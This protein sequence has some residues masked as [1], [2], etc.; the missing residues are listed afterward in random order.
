MED[1][2]ILVPLVGVEVVEEDHQEVPIQVQDQEI[3]PQLVHH[4]EMQEHQHHL[5][6]MVVE[7]EV[8]EL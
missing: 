1:N 2:L 8:Q 7:V 6:E 3:H 5:E 4:K